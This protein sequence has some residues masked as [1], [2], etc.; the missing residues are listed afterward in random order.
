MHHASENNIFVL[1]FFFSID[2]DLTI[3]RPLDQYNVRN[4]TDI[5]L[6]HNVNNSFDEID[7]DWIKK[8][9]NLLL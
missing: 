9:I 1:Q 5:L 4:Q 2:Q 3:P 8:V 7:A 6:V